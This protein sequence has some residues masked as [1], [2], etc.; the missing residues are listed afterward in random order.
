MPANLVK[1]PEDE[2]KWRKAKV[3]ARAAGKTGKNKWRYVV[4]VFERMKGRGMRKKAM[5]AVDPVS[6]PADSDILRRVLEEELKASTLYERFARDAKSPLLAKL[7][8]DVSD[9]EKVH[10]GEFSALLGKLDKEFIPAMVKG[11]KEV[12]SA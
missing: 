4:G 12:S 11:G 5:E 6:K 9:E 1:T 3:I 10:A 2:R 7:L 8:R